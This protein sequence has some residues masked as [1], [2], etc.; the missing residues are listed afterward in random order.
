MLLDDRLPLLGPSREKD[1]PQFLVADR[2][3]HAAVGRVVGTIL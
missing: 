2:V 1:Y 3:C